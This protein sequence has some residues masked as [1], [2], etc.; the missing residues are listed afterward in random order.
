[1]GYVDAL[2]FDSH[3]LGSFLGV[4]EEMSGLAVICVN[5]RL[6]EKMGAVRCVNECQREQ[7]G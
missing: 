6:V 2:S 5:L 4:W 7:D 3:V 1:M